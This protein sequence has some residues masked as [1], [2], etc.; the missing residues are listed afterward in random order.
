MTTATVSATAGSSQYQAPGLCRG[1]RRLRR[2]PRLPRPPC[3]RGPRRRAVR[4]RAPN[5]TSYETPSKVPE[6]DD[7]RVES[8]RFGSTSGHAESAIRRFR[9]PYESVTLS[10]PALTFAKRTL[11]PLWRVGRPRL[12][13]PQAV[14]NWAVGAA[15][16]RQMLARWDVSA[17]HPNSAP[18]PALSAASAGALCT[19]LAGAGWSEALP[20]CR[21]GGPVLIRPAGRRAPGRGARHRGCRP[22]LR[23]AAG[24]S[25]WSGTAR[26]GHSFLGEVPGR[27]VALLSAS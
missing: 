24:W 23:A 20:A 19:G 14:P 9:R 21:G 4:R 22:C 25:P 27:S 7:L 6:L 17:P 8:L 16:A 15:A 10:D 5:V 2:D 26:R 3:R 13:R 18:D 12:G 1:V 11:A